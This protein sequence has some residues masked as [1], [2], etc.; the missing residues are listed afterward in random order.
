MTE[1]A[2]KQLTEIEKRLLSNAR[3][4][5]EILRDVWLT[6]GSLPQ[7][8][9]EGTHDRCLLS[10]VTRYLQTEID[11]ARKNIAREVKS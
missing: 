3:G 11:H 6:L 10:A 5:E 7:I 1:E 9:R 4:T 2:W 8:V